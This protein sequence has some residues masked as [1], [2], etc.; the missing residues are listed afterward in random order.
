MSMQTEEKVF[1]VKWGLDSR[2]INRIVIHW[3]R[4]GWRLKENYKPVKNGRLKLTFE[5]P[6]DSEESH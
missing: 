5:R 2:V 4:K 3:E 1:F 6:K